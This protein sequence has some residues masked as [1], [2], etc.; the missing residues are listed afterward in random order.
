MSTS[1]AISNG[2]LRAISIIIGVVFFLYFLYLVRSVLLYILI[3]AIISLIGRPLMLFFT[4]RL[5]MKS[6]LAVGI[7]LFIFLLFFISIIA[8]F[9]PVIV[10]QY[11]NITQID[12]VKLEQDVD[13]LIGEFTAYFKIEKLNV[14]DLVNQIDFVK[15]LDD[16]R[17]PE[18]VGSIFGGFG[19]FMIG[20][21]SVIFIAF[22]TLKDSKLLEKSLLAFAK[23]EDENKFLNAFNKI[24]KLLSRYFVGLLFQVIIL[25]VLYSILL[26]T[27]GIDNAIAV[28]LIGAFLNLIPYLG[29]IISIALMILFAIT[30]NLDASFSEIILP[31]IV[32]LSGGFIAIQLIDNF[33]NQPII[34]GNSVRSHPLEIFLAILIFGLLFGIGGLIA[35]VPLYTA[36]KVISKEFLSEYKIVQYL[37]KEI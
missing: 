6:S 26:L 28:A 4:E 27:I 15:Y 5:K 20:M 2:I 3:G 19:S 35:A 14:R 33:A 25:F 1:K 11:Q 29:P 32:W 22:F 36:I 23:Q 16:K 30:G 21:F 37:T 9:V 18:L 7:C 12:I 24:K 34:F 13:R 10:E 31:K 8:L 17:I